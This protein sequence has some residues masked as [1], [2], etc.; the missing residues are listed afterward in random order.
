[1]GLYL[2]AQTARD[3]AG[4][5]RRHAVGRVVGHPRFTALVRVVG[6]GLGGGH[7]GRGVRET[8]GMDL[9]LIDRLAV[10]GGL[11]ARGERGIEDGARRTENRAGLSRA[12]R[13]GGGQRPRLG[14][15]VNSPGYPDYR[16][17]LR[18]DPRLAS[19]PSAVGSPNRP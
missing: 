12:A 3:L 10:L 8:L 6:E 1:M 18:E 4:E 15:S 16:P 13:G 7:L 14:G 11:P 17:Q 5:R 2:G 19:G 9:V